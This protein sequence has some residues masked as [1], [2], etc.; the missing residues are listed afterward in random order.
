MDVDNIHGD[1]EEGEID[2]EF[3]EFEQDG[4]F[5]GPANKRMS[6]PSSCRL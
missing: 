2:E 6:G 3:A 5:F 1:G 4:E